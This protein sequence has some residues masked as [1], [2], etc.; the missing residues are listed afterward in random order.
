MREVK[1][2]RLA[3]MEP[4]L[5]RNS[6]EMKECVYQNK[7]ELQGSW[8]FGGNIWRIYVPVRWLPYNFSSVRDVNLPRFA[9]IEPI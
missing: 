8:N 3:G 1:L 5:L 2:P 7:Y 6:R 4:K 9:G